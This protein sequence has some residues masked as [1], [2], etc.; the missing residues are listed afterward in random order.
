MPNRLWAEISSKL[1]FERHH[2]WRA[3]NY[4]SPPH[5]ERP[6][7]GEGVGYLLPEFELSAIF[8]G[9]LLLWLQG[10]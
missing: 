5:T 1:K 3:L 10:V 2:P 6:V 7:N 4:I 9:S 8:L